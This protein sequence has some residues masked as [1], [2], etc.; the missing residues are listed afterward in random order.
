MKADKGESMGL[1]RGGHTTFSQALEQFRKSGCTIL[2][3][4]DQLSDLRSPMS[5]RL[6]GSTEEFRRRGLIL[7]DRSC[8][9]PVTL[10]P[11]RLTSDDEYV[12]VLDLDRTSRSDLVPFTSGTDDPAA[13][14]DL[15][16]LATMS[17]EDLSSRTRELLRDLKDSSDCPE[18]FE[19]RL[20]VATLNPLFSE[21]TT[22]QVIQYCRLVESEIRN[23][24][25]LAHFH[26]RT[27]NDEKVQELSNIFDIRIELRK[28]PRPEQQWHIEGLD[29]SSGWMKL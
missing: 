12:E 16:S 18:A 7:T 13:G 23:Y 17:I 11:G 4:G 10:L 1:Y 28:E 2:V 19:I 26:I 5:W 29:V 27:D 20:G 22:D 6:F 24:R 9:T 21:F 8:G 25:G 3:T 14:P 15:Q